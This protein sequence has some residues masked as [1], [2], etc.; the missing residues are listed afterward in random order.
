MRQNVV[1]MTIADYCQAFERYEV[2]INKRYQRSPKVWPERARSYLIETILK[3]FPVPKLTLHQIT[4]LKSRQTI[5]H[6]VDGQQRTMAIRDFFSG[7]LRLSRRLELSEAAGRT[8]TQLDEELQEAFLAYPLIFD[9]F[10]AATEE[11][12]REYFRRI[13]SF[14]APLNAEE[15]RHAR[16]Q[17]PMKWFILRLADTHGMALVN[18]G[19]V[20]EKS[21][22]RMGDAKLLAE[23]VHALLYGVTTTNKASLDRMYAKFDRGDEVEKEAAIERAI[24]DA[25]DSVIEMTDIHT[26]GLMRT[27][28]FYSL[29][30]AFIR[31]KTAW[32]TL[33]DIAGPNKPSKPRRSAGANLL[34]LAA[35]IEDPEAYGEWYEEFINA[36][37][38]GTNVK[39]KRIARIEWLVSALTE[40]S[41]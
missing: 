32:S 27:H 18:L 14:T 30:L 34:Q 37:A 7:S 2:V 38:T 20:S 17:G 4:D 10:E 16:Y 26:T 39:A 41:I 24:N 15:Q 25:V 21:A 23:V 8:Y 1:T 28:V 29:V 35:A 22:I 13:N 6:V 12:V 19:A 11:D 33:A 31:V 40:A 9:Q 36:S 3:G 5:K